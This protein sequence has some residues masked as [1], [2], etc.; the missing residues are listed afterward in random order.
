M[1][2]KDLTFNGKNLF[3]HIEEISGFPF[4]KELVSSDEMF[5]AFVFLNGEREVF[6]KIEEVFVLDPETTLNQLAK[7]MKLVNYKKWELLYNL[8]ELDFSS[9]SI[10]TVKENVKNDGKN[11]NNISAFDS[12]EMVEDTNENKTNTLNR[13]YQRS[14]KS[15]QQFVKNITMLQDRL[16]YDIIFKDIRETVLKNII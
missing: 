6:N 14:T 16:I 1:K 10:E 8:M 5:H 7:D 12:N 15:V 13:D 9:T 3:T 4:A 11:T 2:F